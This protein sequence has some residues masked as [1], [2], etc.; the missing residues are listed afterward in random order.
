MIDL[1]RD[2]SF[3][4]TFISS[5]SILNFPFSFNIST[6]EISEYGFLLFSSSWSLVFFMEC[7]I[8]FHY[9]LESFLSHISSNTFPALFFFLVLQYIYVNI[10]L[11]IPYIFLRLFPFLIILFPLF[12]ILHIYLSAFQF[13]EVFFFFSVR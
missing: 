2:I 10:L 12:F 11:M 9:I 4:R 6:I 1:I 7:V 5:L 8:S 3:N 13:I